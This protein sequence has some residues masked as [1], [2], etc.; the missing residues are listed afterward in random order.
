MTGRLIGLWRA[1]QGAAL[2]EFALTAPVALL[3]AMGLGDLAYQLYMQSV[4]SGLVQKAGRDATIQ[5]A[6]TGTLDITVL[7]RMQGSGINLT[8]KGRIIISSLENVQ[9]TYDTTPVQRSHWQRCVGVMGGTGYDSSYG[10]TT[11]AGTDT[12]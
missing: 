7:T 5:N 3:M 4:L 12:T 11:T 6:N 8:G 9:Q 1:S 2:I 10:T